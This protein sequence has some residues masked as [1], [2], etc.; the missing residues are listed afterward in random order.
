MKTTSLFSTG[1]LLIMA[2]LLFSCK[3]EQ[4]QTNQDAVAT[5]STTVATYGIEAFEPSIQY[6]DATITGVEYV[7]GKFKYKIKSTDFQLGAQTPDAPQKMCANSAQGQHIH[8]IV[9]DQPYVAQYV[10]EF[11]HSVSD[12]EHYMLSFLSRSYHESIKTAGAFSAKKVQVKGN[13][14]LKSEN[15]VEPMLFYSRPKGNYVGK[16]ETDKVMLDFYLVNTDLAPDGN[17]VKVLINDKQEFTVEIWQPYYITGLPLGENK[18]K[19]TLV[20]KDGNAVKTPLNPVE[21]VF[22]LVDDPAPGQ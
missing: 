3:N 7:A 5:D 18:I 19:L 4:G 22:T 16:A 11:E 20:D 2:G 21:R 17:K 6:P 12:G 9:D 13:S 8:L 15:I 10:P 14:I 1:M